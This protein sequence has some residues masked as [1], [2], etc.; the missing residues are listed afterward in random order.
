MIPVY[1]SIAFVIGAGI[2]DFIGIT[3]VVAAFCILQFTYTFP[4]ILAVA[5]AINKNAMLPDEGFDPAT[6]ITKRHD[7]GI[8][9][10]MRG[11]F[12]GRWYVNIWNVIYFLGALCLAA[13]GGYAAIEN[14]ITAFASGASNS[15]V[16]LSPLDGAG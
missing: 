6:G 10:L 13:L 3:S 11:F 1:W 5:Y 15:F 2:P 16:C 14:L 7:H 4:P 12:A 8:K 9:R